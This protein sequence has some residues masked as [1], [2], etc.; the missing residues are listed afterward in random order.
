M[1]SFQKLREKYVPIPI[2][3]RAEAE[4]QWFRD[5]KFGMFIHWG[6]YSMLGR[7]EWVMFEERID[8]AEYAKLSD[9]FD[10]AKFDARAWAKTASDAGMKYMV[11]TTRHHD[12]FCLFDSKASNFTSTKSA[13]KRDFI[14][15]YVEACRA[16]GLKVGLYYS[17]KDWRFPG[18]FFPELYHDSAVALKEQC[19]AQIRELMTNYGPIDMLWYDGEWLAHGGVAVKPG[20]VCEWTQDPHW[21]T[22]EYLKT[23]FFWES[24][25]LNTMVRELQPNIIVNNRSGWQGDFHSRECRIGG[26]RTDKPWDACHCLAGYW[27]WKQNGRMLSLQS[28]I[29]L[30]VQIAVRDGNLLLNVGPTGSGEIESRQVDRLAQVG[31]WL[32]AYGKSIRGTRGG[33]FMPDSWGGTTFCGKTVYVHIQDWTEETI[34]LSGRS[35]KIKTFVGLTTKTVSV[36]QTAD[37]IEITVPHEHRDCMD[38]I[39]AIEFDAP[40]VFEAPR[41]VEEDCYGTA[42]GDTW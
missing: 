9:Q 31:K 36:N 16:E 29:H 21:R 13:A 18:Y 27:G 28:C 41:V 2:Q 7:G 12:G 20:S 23:N 30:L 42:Y 38:T 10:A 5:A 1:N 17:P 22:S 14:A 26:M 8:V 24:E 34:V 19:W 15:E 40:I 33:P 39:V 11:M 37:R 6:L 35:E 3:R 32:D 4:M 25:K